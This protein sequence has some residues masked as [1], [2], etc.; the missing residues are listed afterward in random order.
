MNP[1]L[2]LLHGDNEILG[3]RL[4]RFRRI[5]KRGALAYAT[6]G[7]SEAYRIAQAKRHHKKVQLLGGY[8][9]PI[10][11]SLKSL[12]RKARGA[13]HST[14]NV[15]TKIP[16][17]GTYASGVRSVGSMVTAAQK[18]GENALGD[19]AKGGV[20]KLLSNNASSSSTTPSSK[21]GYIYIAGGV[22]AIAGISVFLLRRKKS[23]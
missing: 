10:L 6:G 17:V 12:K 5:A 19:L 9:S 14:L 22:A 23:A 18:K 13:A 20:G 11:G 8:E 16:V 1:A 3:S 15:A 21:M 7:G 4:K 2:I